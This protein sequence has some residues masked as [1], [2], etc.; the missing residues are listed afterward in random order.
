SAEHTAGPWE[1]TGTTVY[2]LNGEGTNRFDAQVQ[3]GWA[4]G[5]RLR[6]SD[7]ELAANARV[8]HAV[9]ELLEACQQFVSL[10]GLR[11]GPNDA[12]DSADEQSEPVASAMRAIAKATGETA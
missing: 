10:Y 8:I 6:T 12:L 4:I 9:P 7:A 1:L 2:A 3:R 5:G 11:K